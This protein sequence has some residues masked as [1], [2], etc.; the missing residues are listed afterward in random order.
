MF[1]TQGREQRR[2]MPG[3]LHMPEATVEVLQYEPHVR[4]LRP[5]EKDQRIAEYHAT[6]KR[7]MD[8]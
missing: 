1:V 6:Q 3:T 7:V 4:Q 5:N 2:R 8:Y